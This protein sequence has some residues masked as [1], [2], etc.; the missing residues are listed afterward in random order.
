MYN[1]HFHS[2]IWTAVWQ[3][4]LFCMLPL[5]CP[6]KIV[7]RCWK[8]SSFACMVDWQ[9]W[10]WVSIF[11]LYHAN[12]ASKSAKTRQALAG[13]LGEKLNWEFSGKC[14]HRAHVEFFFLSNAVH[15]SSANCRWLTKGI[16]LIWTQS[17]AL[18]EDTLL[19]IQFNCLIVFLMKYPIV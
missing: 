18:V 4:N 19:K 1:F 15:L 13:S 6:F 5:S 2:K 7:I 16:Y 12:F 8:L 3:T 11:C 10:T 9:G 14:C 17:N